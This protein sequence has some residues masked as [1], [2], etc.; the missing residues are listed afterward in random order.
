[1]SSKLR[2]HEL[3]PS[4]NNQKARIA[5]NYKGLEYERCLLKLEGFPGDRSEIVRASCQ[6]LTPVLE[7]GDRK[8]FDSGAILRYLEAN[9]PASPR[10]FSEDYQE[11]KQI[12]RWE[13]FARAQVSEPVGIIFSGA[14]APN[15]YPDA[16][17]RASKLMH[18][19]TGKIEQQL[20]KSSF[21]VGDSITAADVTA[22]PYVS[23]ATLP[24]ASPDSP[25]FGYFYENF[26]LGDGRDRTRSW[27]RRVLEYD[28]EHRE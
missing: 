24:G 15:E 27:V 11:M 28:P 3:P 25:L 9:F 16:G 1:M 5:L 10:L 4:P 14:F 13:W 2:L 17:E 23:L 22:V 8:I 20:E 18:E 19:S 21:L 6:P 7:H 26:K 12:E